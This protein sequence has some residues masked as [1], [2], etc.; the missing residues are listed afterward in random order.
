VEA[1]NQATGSSPK[2]G[3]KSGVLR[4]TGQSSTTAS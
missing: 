1:G 2:K 3:K 4:R